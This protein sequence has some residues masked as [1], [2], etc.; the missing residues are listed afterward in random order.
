MFGEQLSDDFQEAL[1]AEMP[2]GLVDSSW[3]G[4]II[5]AW[6]P[7]EVRKEIKLISND[8]NLRVC[9]RVFNFGNF[10]SDQLQT[11]Y[12]RCIGPHR[13]LSLSFKLTNQV[14]SFTQSAN[15]SQAELFIVRC[16]WLTL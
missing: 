3:G 16:Y 13:Y 11:V 10:C 14:A 9:N 1:G 6:S 4:T 5:E 7:P 8:Q 2:I 12:K 15:D